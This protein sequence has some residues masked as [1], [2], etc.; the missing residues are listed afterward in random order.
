MSDNEDRSVSQKNKTKLPEKHKHVPSR[1]VLAGT[2]LWT[3]GLICAFEFIRGHKKPMNTRYGYRVQVPAN[4]LTEAS[5]RGLD[6]QKVMESSFGLESRDRVAVSLDEYNNGHSLQPSRFHT[7]ERFDGSYWAPIGWERISDLVKNVQVNGSWDSQQFEWIDNEDDLTVADLAAPYWERPAGPIWWCH[8]AAGNPTV[9]SWLNNAQWLH[10]AVSLALR[11]ESKLISERM[12]HLLYEVP[13]RVA[14]GLLF[15]LL[16]QSVGDPLVE[17]D[18]IPIVLRSWQ[19][20]NFLLTVLHVKGTVSG[21][22][23]LGITEVQELLAAGGH[24]VPRTVHEVI[25]HL[26]CRLTRWDDRLFRKSIFGAADEIELKFMNRRNHEDMNLFAVIMNQEIR[27]LSTQVIRVKWSLHA[28]EEIVFELLQ[29]LRGN[30]ARMLLEGIRK[31][32]REMIEE[33]EAVRGRLFTIQDVMQSTVRAWL[34]DRSLR[35]THNLG[36][37]GGCGLVLTI[38][39]GLFGINVDG[40]P[41]AEGTP[42][43]FGLFTAILIVIGIVLI[44]IGM[45]YLGLREPIN[46]ELVQVRKLELQELVKMFQHEAEAHAQVRKSTYRNNLT[47]TSGDGFLDDADYVLIQ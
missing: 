35:V 13:V 36:V 12:K 23:V 46:E 10:P 26:A 40:I 9:V 4:K 43:A 42:Y 31:N 33:Q 41:G 7:T 39:T 1:D 32:T 14:G 29:H 28:R 16:G 2:D 17:E 38:I 11:D 37:F 20:Q 22:N 44:V 21:V 30:A 45:L 18:D 47:P 3:D 24:N 25:A 8:L 27:R 5:S 19:A 34:Q 6:E 15:E